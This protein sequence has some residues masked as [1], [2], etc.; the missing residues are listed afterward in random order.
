MPLKPFYWILLL[1]LLG[2]AESNSQNPAAPLDSRPA[3]EKLANAYEKIS[4]SIP[5]NPAKMRPQA[6]RR[7]LEEVFGKAGYNYKATLGNLALVPA[8]QATQYHKDLKELLF[9]AHNGFHLEN[10]PDIYSDEEKTQ[11]RTIAE[12]IK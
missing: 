4:E 3:L 9:L 2:C 7:F 8:G 6:R 11:I 1:L 10:L 12:N 5:S